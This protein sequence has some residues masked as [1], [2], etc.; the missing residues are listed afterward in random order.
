MFR[1]LI[2]DDDPV[3]GKIYRNLF[4]RNGFRAEVINDGDSAIES[5]KLNPPNIVLLDLFLPKTPGVN[6]LKF[7]R[8]H[9]GIHQLPVIVFSTNATSRYVDAAW[10]AGATRVI[11]K[12]Q[13][14]PTQIFELVRTTLENAPQ[15]ESMDAEPSQRNEIS[16]SQLADALPRPSASAAAQVQADQTDDEALFQADIR[17][18]FLNRVPQMIA[19]LRGTLETMKNE[20]DLAGRAAAAEDLAKS[21]RSLAGKAEIAGL[22]DLALVVRALERLAK[23]AH[24]RPAFIN[25]SSL[26]TAAQGLDCM[27]RMVQQM[28]SP[29]PFRGPRNS[30]EREVEAGFL[31]DIRQVFLKRTPELTAALQSFAALALSGESDGALLHAAAA[32]SKQ[33]RLWSG[34][35]RT[36]GFFRAAQRC[37]TFATMLALVSDKPNASDQFWRRAAS[38]MA[39]LLQA[40][41]EKLASTRS[42][43][44]RIGIVLVLDEDRLTVEN[45][46]ACLTRENIACLGLDDPTAA[47]SLLEHNAFDLVIAKIVMRTLHGLDFLV[48]FRAASPQLQSTAIVLRTSLDDFS[49]C[50]ET[51]LV[52]GVEWIAEPFLPVELQLKVMALMGG[53]SGT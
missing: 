10:K 43:E 28:V 53:G 47:L 37:M 30:L 48:K 1:I 4:E 52:G 35:A 51:S 7:I 15:E 44:P 13:F 17:R 6:V 19:G 11:G 25:A 26:R 34:N 9:R 33:I 14:D 16:E 46:C 49:G 29:K 23:D 31:A 3:I 12:S 20:P 18:A 42:E 21:A 8:S 2:V 50:L 36:V 38:R 24:L 27:E 45:L 39:S 40:D 22:G 5:L 32:L 41:I